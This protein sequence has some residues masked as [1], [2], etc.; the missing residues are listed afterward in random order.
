MLSHFLTKHSSIY[1]TDPQKAEAYRTLLASEIYLTSNSYDEYLAFF[2]NKPHLNHYKECFA[3]FRGMTPA[4]FA[5]MR[6]NL[7]NRL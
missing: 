6:I 2:R 1:F 5:E 7:L 4:S 3:L